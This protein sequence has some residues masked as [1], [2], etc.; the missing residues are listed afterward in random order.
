MNAQIQEVSASIKALA[1]L[2]QSLQEMV[3]QFKLNQSA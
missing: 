3:A 2:A 1:G